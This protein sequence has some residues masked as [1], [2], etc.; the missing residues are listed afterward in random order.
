MPSKA[1]RHATDHGIYGSPGDV[2]PWDYR[3]DAGNRA[4]LDVRPDG[5]GRV[6]IWTEPGL[7]DGRLVVRAGNL[8][9]SQ[10]LVAMA[11]TRR[12]TFWETEY[13]DLANAEFTFAFRSPAGR[14]VYIVPSGVT[15][16]VERIDRFIAPESDGFA[17]PEWAHGAVI[18][19]IFPDRFARAAPPAEGL[20]TWGGP[21]HSREFQ[22]GDLDGIASKLDHL[23]ELGV[24]MLYLNPIFASPSNHRYDT[25]D[26]YSVDPMLGGTAALD[27][28]I[29]QVHRRNIRIILDASF[30]HVHPH[31]F[32]FEDLLARGQDSAYRDWFVVHDWPLQVRYRPEHGSWVNE[33]VPYWRR[34]LGVPIRRARTR[35][36]VVEPTYDAWYGVPS[37]PRV[38]LANA[39]ARSYMLD[40]ARYWVE[41]HD[42]DGWRMDVARYVDPDFWDDFRN[43]V[44]SAKSDAYL[45]GEIMG[46]ASAWLTGGRFDAT[47]NYTFRDLALAFLAHDQIDGPTALDGLTRLWGQHSWEVTLANQNLLD[48]HDTSRFLTEAGGDQA[49]LE[50]AVLLQMTYPG[51]PGIYYGNEVGLEGGE[52][53]ACRAAF[54]W[55]IAPERHPMFRTFADLAALRRDNPCL[56]HGSWRPL[57]AGN[58]WLAYMRELNGDRLATIINRSRRPATVELP[59]TAKRVL[60]GDPV[61]TGKTVKVTGRSGA[62]L[63]T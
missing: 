58:G 24:D 39:D 4:H 22:G 17:T 8:V 52:D 27:R 30:N 43:V 2:S 53:P 35:G 61:T 14:A 56:R 42:I 20:A 41:E 44:K 37:M 31:F 45:I 46:D 7:S 16:A 19:Q 60:W 38:N 62:V 32:A 33:W 59:R 3:F 29:E 49:R 40:V 57:G 50:L 9:E 55:D 54:P 18:Y 15:N 51:A 63:R 47:M 34:Q 10:R 5:L 13:A 11:A 48:S 36:P 28:L 25:V 12:F 26:Y 21:P 1:E 6:R 23:D